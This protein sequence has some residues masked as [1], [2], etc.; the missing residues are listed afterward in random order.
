M[1]M[2]D[3]KINFQKRFVISE[4]IISLATSSIA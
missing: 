2:Y 1:Q 4:Y 3:R